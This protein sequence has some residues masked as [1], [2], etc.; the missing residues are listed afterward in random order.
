MT[1]SVFTQFSKLSKLYQENRQKS[2]TSHRDVVL[3]LA[4]NAE[5][6][7]LASAGMDTQTRIWSL[8]NGLEAGIELKGH[9]EPI[10]QVLWD[11]LHND[12][13]ATCSSDK[14]VRLWDV[15][16]PKQSATVIKTEGENINASWSPDGSCIAVGNK[17][18]AIS[19]IDPRGGGD[20]K[21][22]KTYIWKVL[23]NDTVVNGLSW[24]WAGDLFFMTLGE[25]IVQILSF[26]SLAPVY[27]LAAHTSSCSSIAFDPRGRYFATGGGDAMT[28]IWD[29]E[30]M[31]C[32][33]AVSRLEY[34]HI[35]SSEVL[36][37]IKTNPGLQ[38]IAF[39]PSKHILAFAGEER[40]K[41]EIGSVHLFNTTK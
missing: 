41:S 34:T 15:R 5:G 17:D 31:L 28:C 7:K 12:K 40:S 2:F 10:N 29:F 19:F 35:D 26:P 23:R 6:R 27:N 24:N 9:K 3:A 4:W 14:T 22:E 30:T 33:G 1:A 13:L 38:C 8:K 37:T 18:D 36:Y 21:S 20:A 39:H 11:P 16:A 25:G 32:T